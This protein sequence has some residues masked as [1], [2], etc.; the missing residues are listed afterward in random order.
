[1][2]Q[3]VKE[4]DTVLRMLCGI[5]M[6]LKVSKVTDKLIICGS[7]EFDRNTGAEIDDELGWNNFHTGSVLR[8]P[9]ETT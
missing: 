2:F 4:G 8:L 7:W 6:P 9:K 5:P 1:M 3:S